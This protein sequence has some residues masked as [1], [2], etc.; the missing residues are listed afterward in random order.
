MELPNRD[1]RPG[2]GADDL[3]LPV[4][5]G[6]RGAVPGAEPGDDPARRA[7]DRRH[8]V[9]ACPHQER[10]RGLARLRP[11]DRDRR[12]HPAEGGPDRTRPDEG[13]R[14]LAD[15]RSGH[16]HRPLGRVPA[17]G[18]PP[19]RHRI[20]GRPA[21]A[22]DLP[23]PGARDPAGAVVDLRPVA[24]DH[25][26]ARRNVQRSVPGGLA[27]AGRPAERRD[28]LAARGRGRPHRTAGRRGDRA[29][30]ADPAR[31]DGRRL[32]GRR[33][34]RGSAGG[35]GRGRVGVG[36]A[37][38]R[39]HPNGR[40]RPE[41]RGHRPALLGSGDPVA[42]RRG[43]RTG[44]RRPA[45]AR[46]RRDVDAGR[47]PDP[48]DDPAAA[49]R[50]PGRHDPAW[51]RRRRHQNADRRPH[52]RRAARAAARVRRSADHDAG[53][54]IARGRR[55][56]TGERRPPRIGGRRGSGPRGAGAARRA[57]DDLAGA[58]RRDTGC[59]DGVRRGRAAPGSVLPADGPRRR[60]RAV[61]R[62]HRRRR[63]RRDVPTDRR[64]DPRVALVPAVPDR[65]RRLTQ[66]GEEADRNAPL[67]APG[68][69]PRTRSPGN[70]AACWRR[71]DSS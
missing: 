27:R 66:A 3:E 57:R 7:R 26:R 47:S 8:P 67:D 59:G 63:V 54:G 37:G 51:A 33:G 62:A 69:Q 23:G 49:G 61:A 24:P 16:R 46:P 30:A 34:G 40:R 12:G 13:L 19:Q 50:R 1:G 36:Q 31:T 18:R 5:A 60:D 70:D 39:R 71:R 28:P 15:A 68:W 44:R 6:A 41:R 42:L 11:I 65:V 58:A 14:G 20:V 55:P 52:D 53:R 21:D 32:S 35:A 4:R 38:A 10:V 56:R 9:L 22:G 17:Q 25:L 2:A 45:P 64:V 29:G 48:R 43:S